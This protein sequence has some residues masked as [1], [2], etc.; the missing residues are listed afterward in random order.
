MPTHPFP[1]SLSQTFTLLFL[2]IGPLKIIGPFASMTRGQ[3]QAFKRLLA[4]QGTAIAAIGALVA[5]TIASSILR[6]WGVSLGALLLTM[7]I[8]LFLIALR[9][10]MEQYTPR[11][12][13]APAAPA[14]G[15]PSLALAFSPL[16]FPT[17]ITPYGIATLVLLETLRSGGMVQFLLVVGGVLVLDL[18]A[19]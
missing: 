11:E 14:A 13:A 2:T 17:I 16:A 1:F 9:T 4:F 5:S 10:V 8:L 12:P 3:D 15:K 6:K 7:G 18:L 19:M